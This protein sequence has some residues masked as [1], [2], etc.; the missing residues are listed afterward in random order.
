MTWLRA[1]G[2]ASVAAGLAFASIDSG[3]METAGKF[4]FGYLENISL[5]KT[6]LQFKAKLDSGARSSSVHA[7]NIEYFRSDGHRWVR[8]T[9][10]DSKGKSITLERPVE[11]FVRIKQRVGDNYRRPVVLMGICLGE[12]LGDIEVNLADRT[13][14]L[15]PFLVGRNFLKNDILVDASMTFTQR[16]KC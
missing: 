15:Y 4:H 14:M 9:L 1:L 13:E 16:P 10:T 5:P 12:V 3:A 8:F 6:G 7:E 11:R 2:T